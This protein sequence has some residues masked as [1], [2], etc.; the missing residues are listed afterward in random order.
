MNAMTPFTRSILV[1]SGRRLHLTTYDAIDLSRGKPFRL[2]KREYKHTWAERL[3]KPDIL[4]FSYIKFREE[5]L[6]DTLQNNL[7][8]WRVVSKEIQAFNRAARGLHVDRRKNPL[9][10]S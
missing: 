9:K 3:D 2:N 4:K 5:T 1:A 10:I 7:A 6:E 8:Y